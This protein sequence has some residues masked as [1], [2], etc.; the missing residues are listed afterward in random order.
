[1]RRCH[2]RRHRHRGSR[3]HHRRH[4]RGSR[5]HRRRDDRRRHR[6]HRDD[7][8][9]HRRGRHRRAG[10][11]EGASCP[12]SDAEASCPG[13]GANRRRH[14]HRS[15]GEHPDAGHRHRER[16]HGHRRGQAG[17]RRD[18]GHPHRERHHRRGGAGRPDGEPDHPR[19]TGC[20]PG[21]ARGAPASA[22]GAWAAP[23]RATDRDA[24]PASTGQDGGRRP[25][26]GPAAAA[27][28]RSWAARSWAAG[29][30]RR[31][32]EPVPEP[33]GARGASVR[34]S[35]R[36]TGGPGRDV[37]RWPGDGASECSPAGPDAA[38]GRDA[39]QGG[40]PH[41]PAGHRPRGSCRP[42]GRGAAP[43]DGPCR[44]TSPLTGGRRRAV[45]AR[46]VPPPWRTR[47]S[48]IR[49][50]RRVSSVLPCS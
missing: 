33:A 1:M 36:R 20:Y 43:D 3:R 6:R 27:A 11:A 45:A 31:A 42:A 26:A 17:C 28:L 15:P 49:R 21:A 32:G 48:R 24:A 18:A 40:G 22:T 35:A 38:R 14:R 29:A 16:H 37:H 39:G 12:G 9:G 4:R 5:R 47:T 25:P 10:P 19:R 30:P 13:S 44:W 46:R 50:G 8:H 2:R 7:R 23:P 41:A 34:V